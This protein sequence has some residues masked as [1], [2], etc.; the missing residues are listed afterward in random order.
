MPL[1]RGSI[2]SGLV[3]GIDHGKYFI[4][5]A[6]PYD[7]RQ[8]ATVFINSGINLNVLRTPELQALQIEINPVDYPVFLTHRS[9]IDCSKIVER[10]FTVIENYLLARPEC[11][12]GILSHEHLQKVIDYL[13][14]ADS[15]SPKTKRRFGL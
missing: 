6:I 9:Y 2:I 13:S 1:Q 15:I 5:A 8:I 10:D 14:D 12:L 3:D 4:V 11:E 7:K